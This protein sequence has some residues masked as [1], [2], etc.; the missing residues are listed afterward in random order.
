MARWWLLPAYAL[1]GLAGLVYEVSWTRWL[2]LVLGH[3]L[4]ATSTVLAV[5]MG[6]LALGAAVASRWATRLTPARA[7]QVY[8]TIEVAIALFALVV[9]RGLGMATPL[10]TVTYREGDGGALFGFV[11]L[12][13]CAGLLLPPAAL[14]GATFPI[15]IRGITSDAHD[16]SPGAGRLYA[17]NTV[18]AAAGAVLSGFLWLP[19]WGLTRTIGVGVAA[20][21]A[22]AG[23]GLLAGRRAGR[24]PVSGRPAD[25][26][27]RKPAPAAFAGPAPSAGPFSLAV[28]IVLLSGAVTFAAEIA[29]TRLVALVIGPSTYAFAATVSA[30]IG[31]LAIGAL[32]ASAL[33]RALRDR[34]IALGAVLGIAAVA[35]A[36][37]AALAGTWLPR[38]LM[39]D[40]IDAPLGALLPRHVLMVA[41][42]IVPTAAALGTAFPL[43]LAWVGRDA[44]SIRR[45]GW[46]Y[47]L[48]TLAS[49]GG[50]LVTGFVVIRI[51]GLERTL[52]GVSV[53]IACAAVLVAA[54][55]AR[56]WTG[57]AAMALPALA[58]VGLGLAGPRWDRELLASGAYKYAA[59][60][61]SEDVETALRAGTLAYFKDGP[62]GTVSVKRLTGQLSL[63]IDGK[64]DASTAGDM[65]TQ[66]L[67][68]HVPLLLHER[69][70]QV[71]V[72]GLGSGVT[73]ASALT[74]PI[75]SVDVLEISP[76]VAEASR[77]FADR[78]ESPLDD[79]RTR[80]LVADGRTHV[81]LSRRR[82]DVLVSEPSNPWMAGVAALFTQEFF[83]G[84][85][86]RLAP[87]G[88]L[89]QWVNTYDIST[90]DLR[91]VVGTF[92]SVFPH[93]T[94]WLVG[95]GDLLML[96]AR[97]P[98][99]DRLEVL[100]KTWRRPRVAD[101]LRTVGVMGPFGV[102]STFLG[103]TGAAARFSAGAPIQ[104]DDR[105]ALEFSTPRA[106]RT[107]ARPNVAQLRASV[108]STEQPAAIA[109]AWADADGEAL[110][111]RAA[112]LRQAGAYEGAYQAALDAIDA[113]P[114]HAGAFGTLVDAAVGSGRHVEA[115]AA[116][117]ALA[118]RHPDRPEPH[119]ARSRLHA[120]RG[121]LDEAARAATDAIQRAPAAPE[122]LEQLASVFADASDARRLEGVVAALMRQ[123][124]SRA[125]A[126]Y[127]R[128][129][130][131][132]MTG[133]LAGAEAAAHEALRIAPDH[134]RAQNL[135]G[136]IRATRG[137]ADAA[138]QA[139]ADAM[140]LD[141]RDPTIYQN[142]ALLELQVRNHAAAARLFA[143]AL[144]LDP[145]SAA[146]RDGL[147]RA[148]APRDR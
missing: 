3:G 83:A 142:L 80:L 56:S 79:P 78:T 22:A 147:V 68:A 120:A 32:A 6:G 13:L 141:P 25:A 43:T 60:I 145:T 121:E 91:S 26:P 21:L 81:L 57:G 113:D 97:E 140:R 63:A 109:R 148:K 107:A 85:L 73:V 2:A 53:S 62:T 65:L 125:G 52:R 105:M 123:D 87:R 122:G 37:S 114:H 47:G 138:R 84:A 110:A 115:L 76:E 128:A 61:A 98:F 90:E 36:L 45:I 146:S 4:A 136:A 112:M 77:L 33:A 51:M 72:I 18:G 101:D 117:Q 31:G 27:P 143:E 34:T 104:T 14:L 118:T 44:G 67:L 50:S 119:L 99:D 124:P 46:L 96:G 89:C 17:A 134:A 92:A 70:T 49:V 139:F 88:V 1:S 16:V 11:R 7:L 23:F 35:A 93:V 82:Y 135:L 126:H 108:L 58:A 19:L 39:T 74:H 129:S 5:F 137:E 66:K 40:F 111:H 24:G 20:S 64:V 75:E 95:E 29:W 127:Y 55:Y 30:F 133:D 42:L 10:L 100:P 71:A 131:S 48:N 130:L 41:A 103:G 94:L 28:V 59:D 15:A 132:F 54:R 86:E 116:L 102:W 38:R 69:P 106:L 144:S 9:G 12:A 8:A